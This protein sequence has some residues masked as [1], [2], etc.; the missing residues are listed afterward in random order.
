MAGPGA[1]RRGRGLAERAQLLPAALHGP[2]V[3]GDQRRERVGQG[4]DRAGQGKDMK[5]L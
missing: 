4:Q 3:A 5:L 1:A 2:R